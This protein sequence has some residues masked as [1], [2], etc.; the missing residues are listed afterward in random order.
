MSNHESTDKNGGLGETEN[1]IDQVDGQDDDP[2]RTKASA[3]NK[4]KKIRKSLTCCDRPL[5]KVPTAK[6]NT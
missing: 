3:C 2:C 6:K 5:Q 4:M 1:G